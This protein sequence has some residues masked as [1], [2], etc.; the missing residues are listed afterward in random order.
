M[1]RRSAMG[2]LAP[3]LLAVLA[4]AGS[5]G[6][7]GVVATAPAASSGTAA[8]VT[9]P[10]VAPSVGI[11]S[12]GFSAS[13]NGTFYQSAALPSASLANATC[14][15][16][17]CYDVSNDVS[18][19]TTPQGLLVAAY[20]QL[21]PERGCPGL[22]PYSVS[23][24]A[25][26]TSHTDGATWSPVAYVGNPNCGSGYPDAWEPSIGSLKNGTLVLAYVEYNLSAGSLPPLP[27]GGWPPTQ[28][29]LVVSESYS[30]GATWTTPTVLNISNPLTAPP[31]TQFTPAL[32]SV[33]TIGDTIY[34]TWMSLSFE[35]LEGGIALAVSS[36]GGR[37]WSPAIPVSVGLGA[38]YSM[39]PKTVVL[40]DGELVIA[41]TT[42]VTSTSFWCDLA[43]CYQ[44]FPYAWVGSVEVATSFYNGTV[45]NYTAVDPSVALGSPGW[46]PY[47]NPTSYG[48][49]EEPAPQLAYSS[50]TGEIYL[51]FT[52]GVMA[53]GTTECDLGAAG[54]L[55][56]DLAFYASA[57]GA[58]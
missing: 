8:A 13:G 30:S 32:P 37:T 46:N 39:D 14:L 54:C 6:V 20:T 26:V 42:N 11:P 5:L 33:A 53:N 21:A 4:L 35:N 27:S 7:T 57:D 2:L 25:L 44:V 24:I 19:V 10:A 16:P 47:V 41:Y 56:D 49:F 29:R 9:S 36:T 12:T 43:G 52:A 22:A 28:S 23:D 40:P 48:P 17:T 15:G 31:G 34:V 18:T 1:S 51:A 45:F 38:Y 58:P 50:T 3:V 55:A